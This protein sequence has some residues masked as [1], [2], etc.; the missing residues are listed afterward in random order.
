MR[1]LLLTHSFNSLAQRLYVELTEREH[2]VSIELDIADSVTEEA[3]ALFQPHLVIAPFMK[4][5]IPDSVWRNHVCLVVHPGIVGDRGPSALDWAILN[6]EAEWGVTVLQANAV[7]DG[8]DIW[9]SET[10]PMREARKS[11]LYRNEVSEAATRCVLAAVERFERGGF[12][13][14]PLDYSKPGVRG[15]ARPQ[16]RQEQRRIAWTQDD[17]DT[18]L[19]KVRASDSVPGVLDEVCEV[20]CYLYNAWPEDR[21]RGVPGEVIARRDGAI[22]LATV[23]GAVWI[24]HLKPASGEGPRFKLPA[25]MVLGDRVKDVP[26]APLDPFQ[27]GAGETWQEVRYEETNGVGYLHFDF[28][29][30]AMSTQQCLRLR[31]AYLQASQRPVKV[32]ALMGGIDFWC[33]GI[34]LNLIEAADSPADESWANINAMNDLCLVLLENTRQLTL[35]AMQGNAGA[36]GVFLALAADQ[37]MAREGV[38]LNPH[39]KGMGNLYGSEYWTYLLPRRVGAERARL[40]TE[41]R[42]PIGARRAR[43]LG[44]L[45]ECFGASVEEFRAGVRARAEALAGG[46]ADALLA[47]KRERRTKDEAAKSLAA[48]RAEELDH[49]KLNFYGFDPSYHVARYHF[50]HRVPHAWTPLHLARHRQNQWA[51]RQVLAGKEAAA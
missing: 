45:D 6:G 30:G 39:Y 23:D 27:P 2:D 4:R 9:A 13:P 5:A 31:D 44:L 38:I 48:Y 26:E 36:G 14:A 32:I 20:A 16:M 43:E 47:V 21:L 3:V 17:T 50:V 46:E 35:A 41:N 18:V 28:Y 37:V 49:M 33:N 12:K 19:R 15:Q 42:L 10:F 51:R 11:S 34:H 25:T 24:T 40:I 29:N 1:I 7:M 22:L 8:G